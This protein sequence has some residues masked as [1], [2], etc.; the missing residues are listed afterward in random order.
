MKDLLSENKKISGYTCRSLDSAEWQIDR[1][2]PSLNL[3]LTFNSIQYQ[4]PEKVLRTGN[5]RITLVAVHLSST[6]KHSK[7]TI[8]HAFAAKRS[9]DRLEAQLHRE[10]A[11][12]RR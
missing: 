10:V 7:K 8:L 6:G 2:P 1:R 12:A 4:I 9:C 11:K 3:I 5:D